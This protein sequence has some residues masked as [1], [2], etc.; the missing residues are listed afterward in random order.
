[1]SIGEVLL[2]LVGLLT[3]VFV[4]DAAVRTFVL[5]AG[6]R[7]IL[8]SP[9]SCSSRCV[10]CVRPALPSC[11]SRKSTYEQ[12]RPGHGAVR[13]GLPVRPRAVWLLLVVGGYTL[14]FDWPSSATWRDAFLRAARRSSRSGSNPRSRLGSRSRFAEAAIGLG[15]L[16]LLIAYLPTIYGTFSRR[17][18]LV[19]QT[20]RRAG[21]AAGR[22]TCCA[23]RTSS[24]T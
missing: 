4:L 6:R 8:D 7:G 16:A 24:A 20:W 23:A 22:W 18:V 17:E 1:M 10:G 14:S 3:A 21:D 12:V 5:P 9:G 19:A 11:G 13:A 2:L 15:L